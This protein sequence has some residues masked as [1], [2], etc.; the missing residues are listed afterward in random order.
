MN[1]VLLIKLEMQLKGLFLAATNRALICRYRLSQNP[2]SVK[3]TFRSVSHRGARAL[4][5]HFNARNRA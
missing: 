5:P 3:M 4:F 2:F 1:F